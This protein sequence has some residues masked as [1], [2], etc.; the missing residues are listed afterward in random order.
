MYFNVKLPLDRR[1]GMQT[2]FL[3]LK[4]TTREWGHPTICIPP[5]GVLASAISQLWAWLFARGVGLEDGLCFALPGSRRH[6]CG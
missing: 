5:F 4:S 2:I 3:K 6:G 1:V